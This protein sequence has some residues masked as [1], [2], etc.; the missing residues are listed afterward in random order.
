MMI[1]TLADELINPYIHD[2][3]P[4]S[5]ITTVVPRYPPSRDIN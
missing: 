4:G 5:V 1:Y 2:I 3:M